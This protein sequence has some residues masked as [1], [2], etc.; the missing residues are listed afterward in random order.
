VKSE[1]SASCFYSV[2]CYMVENYT[3]DFHINM[4]IYQ[5]LSGL[6]KKDYILQSFEIQ[7]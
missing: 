7:W 5:K 4:I 6:A 2:V 3:L 1:K